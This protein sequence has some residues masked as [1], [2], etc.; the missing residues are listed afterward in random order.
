MV[1]DN[2][3]RRL[4][5]LGGGFH[6]RKLDFLSTPSGL[7][8]PTP[9]EN[10]YSQYVVQYFKAKGLLDSS[11]EV[12]TYEDKATW[13]KEAGFK[14][15]VH[16]LG[17]G[18]LVEWSENPSEDAVNFVFREEVKGQSRLFREADSYFSKM[19]G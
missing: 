16:D 2:K 11:L 19:C 18:K 15:G 1:E 10:T 9:E 8:A 12:Y 14:D 5:G 3:A 6:F 13:L 7:G 17:L 4:C